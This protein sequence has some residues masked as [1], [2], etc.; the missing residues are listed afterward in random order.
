MVVDLRLC[1][2]VHGK[3][4]SSVA[5]FKKTSSILFRFINII[6]YNFS[7]LKRNDELYEEAKV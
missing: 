1:L 2:F 3:L 5:C 7:E 6:F 4:N